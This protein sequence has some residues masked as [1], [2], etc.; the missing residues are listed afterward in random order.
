MAVKCSPVISLTSRRERSGGRWWA[1]SARL[2]VHPPVAGVDASRTGP[3]ARVPPPVGHGSRVRAGNL[4]S[5]R[6][7]LNVEA[8]A[9]RQQRHGPPGAHL[10][11]DQPRRRLI[12]RHPPLRRP[13]G[14]RSNGEPLTHDRTALASRFRCPFP[15]ETEGVRIDDLHVEALRQI[16]GQGGLAL[17]P[18]DRPAQRSDR[19]RQR[20]TPLHC[21]PI[22]GYR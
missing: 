10:V 2:P 19:F 9:T 11:D 3:P 7:A 22:L 8:R 5:S 16:H 6:T 17:T 1:G 14:C 21:R 18:W 12:P 15:V 20:S 4:S 13:H